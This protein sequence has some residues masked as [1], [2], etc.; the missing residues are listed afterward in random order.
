MK[1]VVLGGSFNPPTIAHLKL[2]L[3]ALDAVGAECGIFLP[4]AFWY[5]KRKLK[6]QGRQA[7]MLPDALRLEMLDSLCRRDRR[8]AVS[9]QELRR[10]ERG[11]NY[12]SMEQLQ[13]RYPDSQLYFVVGADKLPAIP[14]WHRIQE[15]AEEFVFLVAKRGS[16]D[17]EEF[18]TG[19]PFYADHPGAFQEFRIPPEINGVSSSSFWEKLNGGDRAAGTLV[20]EEVWAMLE[21]QGK[22]PWTRIDRFRDAYAFLSNFFEAEVNYGGLTYGSNE[23]AFQAQK[24]LSDEEKLPFT[25]APPS[26]AKRM[27]RRV[28]LRPNWEAV[29]LGLMEEIVRAKFTQHPELAQQLMATGD[30]ALIEGNTWGDTFWGVD[31]RSGKGENHLGRI[32]MKIR[33]ELLAERGRQL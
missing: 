24:C 2:M 15:F 31:T 25:Q 19:H 14:H 28:P 10:T 20:T 18:K 26:K 33:S 21:R 12:E 22:V 3:A 9:D 23:A 5:V 4:A 30:M 7:D 16:D 13:A 27:G 29:K 1:I 6:R 8:L 32:L 11:Y 17:L